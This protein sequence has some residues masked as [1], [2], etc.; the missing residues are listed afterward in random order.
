MP[1][2]KSKT[3]AARGIPI[4]PIRNAALF[5]HLLMPLSVG[6]PVPLRLWKRPW[7]PKIRTFSSSPKNLAKLVSPG[8][9]I[10]IRSEPR[11]LSK[12]YRVPRDR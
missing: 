3:L 6:R 10:C 7:L 5:P 11:P 4:L 12:K 1:K 8:S 2:K 9:R